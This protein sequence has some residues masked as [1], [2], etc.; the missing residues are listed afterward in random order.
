[1]S[2]PQTGAI[3]VSLEY[4]VQED[5]A[6]L[7][8]SAAT[9]L[10]IRLRNPAGMVTEYD[11]EFKTDGSDGVLRYVTTSADELDRPGAWAIQPNFSLSGFVGNL[12]PQP[13]YVEPNL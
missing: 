2:N 6:A 9:A 12:E 5:G 3:G 1:M 4:T 13:F 8:I 11:A 7:D 10:K